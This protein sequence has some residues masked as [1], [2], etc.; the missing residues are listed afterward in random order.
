MLVWHDVPLLHI[1][2]APPR[3]SDILVVVNV[4]LVCDSPCDRPTPGRSSIFSTA[5]EFD[6][7][8]TL[9]AALVVWAA[10][11]GVLVIAVTK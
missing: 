10:M 9:A 5:I 3:P 6:L 1:V 4:D 2:T 7:A 11:A 8:T